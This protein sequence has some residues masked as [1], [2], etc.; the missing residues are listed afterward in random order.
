VRFVPD[1]G[2]GRVIAG[3]AGMGGLFS[4]DGGE[5]GESPGWNK[6]FAGGAAT[7]RAESVGANLDGA[8]PG[9]T[10]PAGNNRCEPWPADVN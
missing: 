3:G 6:E 9:C 1:L 7:G 5:T 10:E 2:G 8:K 4:K